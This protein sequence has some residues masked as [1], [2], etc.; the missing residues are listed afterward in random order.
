MVTSPWHTSSTRRKWLMPV[1]VGS[2]ALLVALSTL[3]VL[4]IAREVSPTKTKANANAFA[5]PGPPPTVDPRDEIPEPPPP[6]TGAEG[7]LAAGPT[8]PAQGA[9][10]SMGTAP[11]RAP[12]SSSSSSSA[13]TTPSARSSGTPGGTG[14]K[15]TNVNPAA[16][17]RVYRPF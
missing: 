15:L 14:K 4:L 17:N 12:V 8:S 16:T 11:V 9:P 13:A 5:A 1:A 6:A 2:T 10:A 3:G 7:D